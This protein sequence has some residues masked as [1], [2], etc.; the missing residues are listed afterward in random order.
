MQESQ[1]KFSSSEELWLAAHELAAQ[2]KG[3]EAIELCLPYAEQGDMLAQA[4]IGSLYAA[5]SAGVP[6]DHDMARRWLM[7]CAE[8][9]MAYAQYVL[10]TS[11]F[12]VGDYAGALKYLQ[13]AAD[14][15]YAG[16]Y[17]Q[18]GK[19]YSYGLG[20]TPDPEKGY[21]YFLTAHKTGNLF[22]RMHIAKLLLKGYRGWT[23]RMIGVPL[24]VYGVA[25][26]F[27][28]A[29]MTPYSERLFS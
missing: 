29:V 28:A 13:E 25:R 3:P 5:G 2:K 14:Q 26:A 19:M 15:N 21:G 16:A 18:L 17:L 24:F 9:G 23:G 8:K 10:G 12:Q 1:R 22:A 7:P 20:T 6:T 27:L 11:R 4:F